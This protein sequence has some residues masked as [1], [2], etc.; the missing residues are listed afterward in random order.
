VFRTVLKKAGRQLGRKYLSID[1]GAASRRARK[2]DECQIKGREFWDLFCL[3]YEGRS[4]HFDLAGSAEVERIVL[5]EY[6]DQVWHGYLE[7]VTPG[8]IYGYRI[9]GPYAPEEGHRFNPNKLLLDPY[10]GGYFGQLDWN[11]AVFGYTMESGDDLTFDERDSAGG[12]EHCCS[13]QLFQRGYDDS[14]TAR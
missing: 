4:L 9:H 1:R 10:A 2:R 8:T 5:P 13:I 12:L 7:G 14:V 3:C 6:T 11:P